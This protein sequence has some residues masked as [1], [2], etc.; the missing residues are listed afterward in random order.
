[1]KLSYT[2]LISL[3][4]D[5]GE[6]NLIFRPE[7]QVTIHGP[8]GSRDLLALV[9]TGADNTIFPEATASA[10]GI[11]LIPTAGPS[12]RAYGGQ[13]ISLSY[14]HVELELILEAVRWQWYARVFFAASAAQGESVVLG[15]QGFLEYF[16]ATFFGDECALELVPNTELPSISRG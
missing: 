9:D 11:P 3:A 6:P 12:A 5:T 1:M 4:P 10:L 8:R 16:T 14:A 15:H 7:I 2:G 13:A